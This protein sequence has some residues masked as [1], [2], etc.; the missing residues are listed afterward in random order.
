MLQLLSMYTHTYTAIYVYQLLTLTEKPSV[1]GK[2]QLP[3]LQ[4]QSN[5]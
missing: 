4:A 5:I 3:N 1:K 2:L